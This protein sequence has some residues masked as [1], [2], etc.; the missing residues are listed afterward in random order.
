MKRNRN[1]GIVAVMVLGVAGLSFAQIAPNG[2]STNQP[3]THESDS[4]TRTTCGCDHM[5][6]NKGS[7]SARSA[8]KETASRGAS[9]ACKE[10]A[11]REAETAKESL[12][13]WR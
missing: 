11:E 7:D 5:M 8:A 4:A 13:R 6:N 12:V 10:A 2:Q 3:A 1:L 9:E